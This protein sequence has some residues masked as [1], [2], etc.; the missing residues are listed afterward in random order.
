METKPML[1]TYK[2]KTI[3]ALVILN[4]TINKLSKYQ[5]IKSLAFAKPP[6]GKCI[7]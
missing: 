5:P 6:R 7:L 3:P 4:L 1:N 2:N